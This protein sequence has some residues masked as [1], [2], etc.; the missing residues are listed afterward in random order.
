MHDWRFLAMGLL[1]FAVGVALLVYPRQSQSASQRFE[2][3]RTLIPFP[4]L[5]GVP[6]WTVRLFGIVSLGGAALFLY[7]LLR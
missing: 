3:G 6:V 7:L 2:Q 5:V 1:W 4:P